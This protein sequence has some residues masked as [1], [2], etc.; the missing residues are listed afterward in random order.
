LHT[1]PPS[2]YNT[3]TSREGMWQ[4]GSPAEGERH[5]LLH[6]TAI[7]PSPRQDAPG[8]RASAGRVLCHHSFIPPPF[9]LVTVAA[10]VVF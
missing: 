2:C 6:W 5:R 1:L 10:L 8:T 4:A 3:V 9:I 7:P